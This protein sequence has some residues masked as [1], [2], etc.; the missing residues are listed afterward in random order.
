MK[1][2]SDAEVVRRQ[3]AFKQFR[4]GIVATQLVD[5]QKDDIARLKAQVEWLRAAL[6]N[7]EVSTAVNY[8]QGDID[9]AMI[10]RI[11]GGI[12]GNMA[13]AADRAEPH[14]AASE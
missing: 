10:D 14:G 9:S 12:D 11:I 4:D 13:V 8:R 1:G 3:Q 5:E 2:V 6:I 7:V